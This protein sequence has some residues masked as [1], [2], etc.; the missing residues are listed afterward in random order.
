[1]KV[2]LI[3]KSD[4]YGVDEIISYTKK[5][6][7]RLDIFFGQIGEVFPKEV[8]ENRYDI[9][10]SY[11][12]PWIIP[13]NVLE[14]TRKWNINFHPGPPE[15]PGVGCFNFAL[16]DSASCFGATAHL[17]EEKVDIGKIIGVNRFKIVGN[18]DVYS[19]SEKT[20]RSQLEL[21]KKTIKYIFVHNSLPDSD[22]IWTRKP[23]KRYQLEELSK[24][25]N[26][27]SETEVN[28]RIRS[29]YLKGKPAPFIEI[30]GNKFEY[31]PER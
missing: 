30:F 16:Y 28:K 19:L 15:Y 11:L 23:F 13:K 5:F 7:K 26:S 8:L 12:S 24:I 3:L 20:Y 29:T 4:K 6:T 31:N 10:I 25:D 17:M 22:E 27:M 14:K 2:C 9:C 21:Y 18:E 1:M